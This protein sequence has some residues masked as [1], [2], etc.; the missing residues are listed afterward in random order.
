[1]QHDKAEVGRL[2]DLLSRV[3]A[4]LDEFLK[5][6]HPDAH[7][8]RENW[9][10]VLDTPLPEKGIGIDAVTRELV[11]HVIPNGSSLA[12]PGFT[13]Y[14]T[15]GATTASTLAT[16]AASIAAPQ[17]YMRTA[18]NFIEELS[19]DWLAQ[20]LGLGAMKGVYSSGGSVANLIGLG[21]ARQFAFE[22]LG[23]DPARD[24]S[25]RQRLRQ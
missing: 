14:I 24:G 6:E 22:K 11:E 2:G 15:T 23:R 20:M 21:A 17:R 1:M 7:V 10:P 25:K 13:A 8:N 18:F 16:T 5:F 4:G 3:G 9:R 19:L 12:R